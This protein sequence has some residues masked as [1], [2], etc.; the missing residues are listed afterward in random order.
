[1]K[2]TE[3]DMLR[4]SKLEIQNVTNLRTEKTTNQHVRCHQISRASFG[5]AG[6]R[7]RLSVVCLFRVPLPPS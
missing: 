6:A 2:T 3:L 1:M 7:K 5:F 4:G